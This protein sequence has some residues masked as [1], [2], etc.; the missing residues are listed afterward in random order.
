MTIAILSQGEPEVNRLVYTIAPQCM[1]L[2]VK[3]FILID[4]RDKQGCQCFDVMRTL[5]PSIQLE[6]REIEEDFGA[7]RNHA[8]HQ[9]E[10]DWVC[11]LDADEMISPKFLPAL[12]HLLPSMDKEKVFYLKR[13]NVM[14]DNDPTPIDF[15]FVP[16]KDAPM[17][18]QGRILHTSSGYTYK[19]KIHEVLVDNEGEKYPH[20]IIGGTDFLIFHN[21]TSQRLSC[22]RYSEWVK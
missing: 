21:K 13:Q 3:I 6:Y 14:W 17:D 16:E 12:L 20:E 5:Y 22:T 7:H 10:N 1:E 2:N 9:I 18:P 11:F 15:S 4:P 19:G 8:I